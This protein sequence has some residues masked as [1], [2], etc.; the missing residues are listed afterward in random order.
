[1]TLY[2]HCFRVSFMDQVGNHFSF[3]DDLSAAVIRVSSISQFNCPSAFGA[4]VV[5]L[6]IKEDENCKASKA[7]QELIKWPDKF[8]IGIEYLDGNH[9]TVK[10][11]VLGQCSLAAIEHSELVATPQN[12]TPILAT[13]KF[14]Y[15]LLEVSHS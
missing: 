2:K 13:A 14:N 5:E 3:S 10:G 4:E 8:V 11:I 7:M 12:F 15:E 1:M 9:V 6:D